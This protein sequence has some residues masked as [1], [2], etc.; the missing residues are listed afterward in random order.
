MLVSDI[1]RL[2]PV[3]PCKLGVNNSL[4]ADSPGYPVHP[5]QSFQSWVRRNLDYLW[6]SSRFCM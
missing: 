5:C 4:G 2:K 1:I 6:S 3:K